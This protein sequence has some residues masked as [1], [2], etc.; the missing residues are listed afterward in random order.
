[1]KNWQYVA[2]GVLAYALLTP[3][4]KKKETCSIVRNMEMPRIPNNGGL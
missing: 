2:A 4:S 3:R 1:M